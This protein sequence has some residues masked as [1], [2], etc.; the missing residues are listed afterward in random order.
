MRLTSTGNIELER[1]NFVMASVHAVG[2]A[3]CSYVF[4]IPVSGSP[5]IES[6]A[7]G[8]MKERA[9]QE[10]KASQY[11]NVTVER[12]DRWF[13]CPFYWEEHTT[14]SADAITFTEL[15]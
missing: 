5:D 4:W 1:A 8:A 10:G 2:R 6:K 7:W 15:K 11:V 9:A 13:F 14:V 12:S 3:H